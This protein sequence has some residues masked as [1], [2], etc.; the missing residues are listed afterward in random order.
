MHLA[1]LTAGLLEAVLVG[2]VMGPSRLRAHINE[3]S[4]SVASGRQRL[5]GRW[6]DFAIIVWIPLVLAILVVWE[7]VK[8]VREPYSG[9]GW[10]FVIPFGFG[11]IVVTFLVGYFL[12]GRRWRIPHAKELDL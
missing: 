1:L 9:Y 8:Q 6:W 4:L 5:L 12:T 2:W 10:S 3:S 7:F 11:W